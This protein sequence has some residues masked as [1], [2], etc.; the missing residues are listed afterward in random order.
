MPPALKAAARPRHRARLPL[1]A[2]LFCFALAAVSTSYLAI[3]QDETVNRLARYDDAFDA[4]QGAV[5]LMRF[6]AAR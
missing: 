3:Q 1:L 2:V 6:Q 4:G 5:E